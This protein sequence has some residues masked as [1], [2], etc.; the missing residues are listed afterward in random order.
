[1]A[2]D[3]L[4]K[5]RDTWC[6]HCDK[7]KGCKIYDT[8]PQGCRDFNCLWLQGVGEEELRPDKSWVVLSGLLRVNVDV[9]RPDAW[10]DSRFQV[11]IDDVLTEGKQ[12]MI[13]CGSKAEVLK[14]KKVTRL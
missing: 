13:S 9:G 3:D 5:P 11:L 8:R 7:G 2:V 10:R 14:P 4:D 1:M 6:T 12:V